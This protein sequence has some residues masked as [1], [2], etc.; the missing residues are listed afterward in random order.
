MLIWISIKSISHLAVEDH[1]VLSFAVSRVHN[2]S[3]T[4]AFTLYIEHEK[5]IVNCFGSEKSSRHSELL[6][7]ALEINYINLRDIKGVC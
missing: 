5:Q 3:W 7:A 4:I 6:F 1:D 2:N